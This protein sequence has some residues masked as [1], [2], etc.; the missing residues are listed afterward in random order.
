MGETREPIELRDMEESDLH[1]VSELGI[2]SKQWWNYPDYMQCVFRKELTHGPDLLS[3]SLVAKVA[4]QC[5]RIVGYFTLV[6][7]CPQEIELDFMFVAAEKIGQ[8]IGST[9]MREA[10]RMAAKKNARSLVLIADPHAVGFYE[11]FGAQIF[12]EHASSIPGRKIPVMRLPCC[13]QT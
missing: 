11:K 5:G 6:Q 4:V 9:M 7:E 8:G 2:R 1:V 3:K 13:R 10:I 12:G